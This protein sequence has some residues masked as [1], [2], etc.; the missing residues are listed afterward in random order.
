MQSQKT[1]PG[2][3]RLRHKG[4]EFNI[5]DP[6]MNTAR[7]H[8]VFSL[9]H[10]IIVLALL[11]VAGGAMAHDIFMFAKGVKQGILTGDVTQK[12]REGATHVLKLQHEVVSPRDAASGQATG[13]VQ[14]RPLVMTHT[15][16]GMA[17]SLFRAGTTNEVLA[18]VTSQVFG[19]GNQGTNS[20]AQ[21]IK[22]TNASVVSATTSTVT[23]SNGVLQLM[24]EL[25]FGYQKIEVTDDL[26]NVTTVADS[27]GGNI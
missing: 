23:Q 20:L 19:Q 2:P 16:D 27:M 22:L 10:A 15:F 14:L 7:G 6:T 3:Q 1:R 24:Q 18:D 8:K 4:A 5:Q 25:S 13:R 12:G 17:V 11:T 9:R 26:S 21:T